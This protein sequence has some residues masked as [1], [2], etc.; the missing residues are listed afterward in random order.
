[1]VEERAMP[2]INNLRTLLRT[3]LSMDCRIGAT[4]GKA[5]CGVVGATGRGEYSVLGPSVNLAA[6]LMGHKENPGVLVDRS[7]KIKAGSS[8]FKALEPVQAKGYSDPV[9]IYEPERSMRKPWVTI[10]DEEFVGREAQVTE[11]TF[12]AQHVLST[13]V[14]S[15]MVFVTAPYGTG[16]SCLLASAVRKIEEM[17]KTLVC[18]RVFC[19]DDSFQP[20]R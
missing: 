3:E 8:P 4:S 15:K 10:N 19:E 11:L 9:P 14:A 6:R 20:F 7:L 16:K 13:K 2:V 18:R 17:P 1:M 5:Y 12:W